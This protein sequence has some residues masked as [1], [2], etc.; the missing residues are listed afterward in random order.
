MEKGGHM[1]KLP[2]Y[3]APVSANSCIPGAQELVPATL[4][5]R[6]FSITRRTLSRWI[7]D[8][9]LGFPRPTEINGRLYFSRFDLES[10]KILRARKAAGAVGCP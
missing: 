1:Q 8:V 10:W 6:E 3:L 4:V 2:N 9:R 5:A 7:V